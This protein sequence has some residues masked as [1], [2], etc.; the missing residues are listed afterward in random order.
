MNDKT[1]ID[2]IEVAKFS[3]HAN[4]WWDVNGPLKTLHDI[5]PVRLS[6]IQKHIDLSGKYVL[7]I[8]CGGGILCEGMAKAGAF[9]TGLDVEIEAI[10]TAKNHAKQQELVIQYV[11]Q[12]V[13]QYLTDI[14]D[15]RPLFDVVTCMEMLEHV[16]DP[17]QVLHHA[18]RLLKPG[19]LLFL[20][21]INRTLTAYVKAILAAEYIFN[22][23]PRQTHDYRKFLKP[24]E[25]SA[26]VRAEGF[27][28]ESVLGLDYNPFTRI[29]SLQRDVSINYLM[30][31]RKGSES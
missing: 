4:Q 14:E 13:E 19:G 25:L 31:C 30:L 24:S 16:A 2:P 5:N 20:S 12:P 3:Q 23:L 29:A 15:A 9:V 26:M 21:T 28:F 18:S 17:R 1:T 27:D 7:D 22:I 8:G 11:C 6:F 10:E